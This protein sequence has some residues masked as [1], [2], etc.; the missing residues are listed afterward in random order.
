MAVIKGDKKHLAGDA[1][2]DRFNPDLDIEVKVQGNYEVYNKVL[3]EPTKHPQESGTIKWFNAFGVRDDKGKDAD[4][5]YTVTL[6]KLPPNTRLY[7]LDKNGTDV[8]E[9]TEFE[10][11]SATHIRFTLSIGDPATGS[12]P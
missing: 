7:Y 8:H 12:F 4:V 1:K 6:Q 11:A 2:Y 9:I 10:Q 3:P 5:R